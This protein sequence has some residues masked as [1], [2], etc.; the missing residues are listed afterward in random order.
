M[1][2]DDDVA[3]VLAALSGRPHRRRVALVGPAVG[4]DAIRRFLHADAAIFGM[5]PR[6]VL[7][8]SD[9]AAVQT[10]GLFDT[11]IVRAAGFSAADVAKMVGWAAGSLSAGGVLIAVGIDM[12]RESPAD[13][14]RAH[15]REGGPGAPISAGLLE[16]LLEGG[17]FVGWRVEAASADALR[18]VAWTKR[19]LLESPVRV[20]VVVP[21][22]NGSKTLARLESALRGD[23]TPLRPV[24]VDNGSADGTREFLAKLPPSGPVVV[25]NE[26]DIGAAGAWNLGL[27]IAWDNGAEAAI[28]CA[29]DVVPAPDAI[30]RLCALVADGHGLVSGTTADDGSGLGDADD[31]TG[32]RLHAAPK[33]TA[34]IVSRE[35]LST[36]LFHEAWRGST[37]EWEGGAFDPRIASPQLAFEDLLRRLRDIGIPAFRDPAVRFLCCESVRDARP[38]DAF[39][40]GPSSHDPATD[41]VRTT[42]ERAVAAAAARRGIGR[43]LR[44]RTPTAAATT[45]VMPRAV[46]DYLRALRVLWCSNAPWTPTGYGQQTKLFLRALA[47]RGHAV[48]VHCLY[49]LDYGSKQWE[50]IPCFPRGAHPLGL[51]LVSAHADRFEADV[52]VTLLDVWPFETELFA[53]HVRWVP[54]VPVDHEPMPDGVRSR[55]AKATIPVA[56]SRFGEAAARAAGLEPAYVPHGVD[57]SVFAPSDQRLAR[58]EFGLPHDAFVVGMVAANKDY[59][60]RKAFPQCFMAFAELLKLEPGAVLYV[61]SMTG[62]SGKRSGVDLPRLAES[63]GITRSVV[64]ADQYVQLVGASDEH[65][66]RLYAAFDILLNPSLGEGFGVPILEA[67][68]CGTPVVV[69]DWTSMSELCFA[70]EKIAKQDAEA[71][72]TPLAAWQFT[73][74]PSAIAAACLRLRDRLRSGEDLA[75]VARAAALPF[76]VA[77]VTTEHLEPVLRR[78]AWC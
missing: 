50:G 16:A 68:A 46:R 17:G 5:D 32:D 54:W 1:P 30:G 75:R 43:R 69:G 23:A 38:A 53:S 52:V 2:L 76:D 19:D 31:T 64:F 25:I 9:D 4:A 27:R 65:M 51:D 8:S 33:S 34:F 78:A 45:S 12:R 57:T 60:S 47:A 71:T 59:P 67:Q 29:Q 3:G 40:A 70:G 18:V 74:R 13:D 42:V 44:D 73:P 26:R 63:L 24:F 58:R 28:V 35:A 41:A 7:G 15:A 14:E 20:Y 49:G 10:A 66:A 21:T 6:S 37:S 72:W 36:L 55:L 48:A 62:D 11:V 22:L 39:R 77:R 56:M 61:H